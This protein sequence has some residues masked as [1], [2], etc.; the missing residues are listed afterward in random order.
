MEDQ[1]EKSEKPS[2]LQAHQNKYLG[3][4]LPKETK[5]LFS[6]NCKTLTKETKDNT[7]RKTHHA[8]GLEESILSKYSL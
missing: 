8:L 6:E 3:T 5:D 4:N 2:H 1:K 7:N